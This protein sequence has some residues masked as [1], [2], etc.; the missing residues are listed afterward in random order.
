MDPPAEE[1]TDQPRRKNVQANTDYSMGAETARRLKDDG[2]TGC[3]AQPVLRLFAN[4]A[5][6][7]LLGQSG[8]PLSIL[9]LYRL[10]RTR[11]DSEGVQNTGC[12]L[13]GRDES[14]QHTGLER[15]VGNDQPN[16]R[17]AVAESAV[18]GVLRSRGGVSGPVRRFHNDVG[19]AAIGGGIVEFEGE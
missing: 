17:I 14:L 3:R 2:K 11:T 7:P 16:V 18:L 8:Q 1:I 13:R 12:N 19:S 9:D 10:Q 4:S 5:Q 15:R 6:K